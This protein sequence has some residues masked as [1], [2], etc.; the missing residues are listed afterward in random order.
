M[1]LRASMMTV[2]VAL[3]GSFG[4]GQAGAQHRILGATGEPAS[5]VPGVNALDVQEHL[6]QPIPTDLE[7][8]DH[9]GRA[10]KLSDYFTGERPVMLTFAYHSC[11]SM[12]SLVLDAAAQTAEQL[13]ELGMEMGEDYT[14]LTISIDPRDTPRTASQKRDQMLA[15]SGGAQWDFLVGEEDAIEAATDA[16]GFGF[17]YDPR[18]EQ[19]AHAA[20]AM[21]L[22]PDGK[23]ARYLYG[24]RF[25][26]NDARLA[27]LE[28]SE[29]RSIST[30]NR[31]LLFCYSYDPNQSEY[32]LVAENVMKIGGG[33]TALLLGGF[34]FT[35]WR[36]ERRR[37][38]VIRPTSSAGSNEPAQV[39]AS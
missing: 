9:E 22:T 24:L 31:L 38:G 28:A 23:F 14:M 13:R 36:R 17:F 25:P 29:G 37:G 26:P 7:F 3:L 32:V 1:I 11:A 27:I 30:M 8:T 12:C 5:S 34:L 33:L 39:Q 15:K 35:L 20:V 6:G 21:F 19:Y 18:Q 16:A 2:C 10:V 4:A